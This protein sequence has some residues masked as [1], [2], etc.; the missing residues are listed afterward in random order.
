MTDKFNAYIDGYNLY[1]GAL[2]DRPDL[3]WLDLRALA[4]SYFTT[5]ELDKVY[6]FSA[7]IGQK[8]EGDAAPKR[9]SVY[10]KA[11]R[12][13]GV[14]IVEG[15]FTDPPRHLPLAE[16]SVQQAFLPKPVFNAEGFQLHYS[17]LFEQSRPRLPEVSVRKQTEK[18]SD[19]N[20][21]TY[22]LRDVY[23][24]GLKYALVITADSDL[25]GALKL[26]REEEV[27]IA[28]SAARRE[29]TII[30]AELVAHAD[31]VENIKPIQL[32]ES[33][34]NKVVRSRTGRELIRPK[35]W[36]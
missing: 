13:N 18:G 36:T 6:F 19:V 31:F 2:R 24:S 1:Y 14:E 20:L 26:A 30:P 5:V 8:Y 16:R 12:E 3:K 21:A 32:E 35:E 29:G 9:Q 27:F 34:L 7:K 28:L 17:K 11:L 22:L 15:H 25:A 33:Q 10:W 23:K 4:K